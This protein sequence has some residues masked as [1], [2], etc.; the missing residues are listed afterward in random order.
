MGIVSYIKPFG[1]FFI[2]YF[3]HNFLFSLNY[4][5]F[6]PDDACDDLVR[7]QKAAAGKPD[8]PAVGLGQAVWGKAGGAAAVL[9]RYGLAVP[10]PPPVFGQSGVQ[11][12]AEHG[13]FLLPAALAVV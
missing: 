3:L 8:A 4:V 1:K 11:S 13:V 9:I 10:L 12:Q 6:L 7:Q 2:T 5:R